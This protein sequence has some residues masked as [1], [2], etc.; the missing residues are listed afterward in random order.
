[1]KNRISITL[2][3]ILLQDLASSF[4]GRKR[5]QVIEEALTYWI[6]EHRK[7]KLKQDALKIMNSGLDIFEVENE[8]V[9]DGLDD[10]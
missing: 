9:G 2:D 7:H 1:M 8:T 4:P 3:H 10:L 5:S 6:R